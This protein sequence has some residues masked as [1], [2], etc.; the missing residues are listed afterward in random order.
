MHLFGRARVTIQEKAARG[1]D[2]LQAVVHDRVGQRI[3]HILPDINVR[4]G[5]KAQLSLVLHVEPENVSG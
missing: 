5:R 4:L 2:F 3:R 1:V